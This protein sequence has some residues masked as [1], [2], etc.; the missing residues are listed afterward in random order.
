VLSCQHDYKEKGSYSTNAPYDPPDCAVPV[1]VRPA[2]VRRCASVQLT[3]W[4]SKAGLIGGG[5]A[6]TSGRNFSAKRQGCHLYSGCPTPSVDGRSPLQQ[7]LPVAPVVA[8]H[9][10][11]AAHTN[12][13]ARPSR[14]DALW[15]AWACAS[16]ARIACFTVL[17]HHGEKVLRP[18]CV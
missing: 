13:A 10:A 5:T 8:S 11:F 14:C 2:P 7:T 9:H 6:C 4:P 3:G 17:P 1:P 16:M 18:I 15:W 12:S